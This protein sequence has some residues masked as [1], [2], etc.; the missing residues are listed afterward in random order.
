[1][2]YVKWVERGLAYGRQYLEF[3]ATYKWFC[4]F[5]TFAIDLYK[6]LFF[7]KYLL[8]LYP[9]FFLKILFIYI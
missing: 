8:G 9:L 6:H 3:I 2:M 5:L 1:M 4:L 7:K